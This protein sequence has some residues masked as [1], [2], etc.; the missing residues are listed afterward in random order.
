MAAVLGATVEEKKEE[1][2]YVMG[3][4]KG[5]AIIEAFGISKGPLTLTHAAEITGHTKAAS[6]S[7]RAPGW[8]A[9]VKKSLKLA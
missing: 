9:R 8:S 2:E 4:E 5:L 7:G 3:L 1:K 6:A